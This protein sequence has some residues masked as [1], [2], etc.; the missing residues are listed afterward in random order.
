[1]FFACMLSYCSN[2]DRNIYTGFEPNTIII[3][4]RQP[5][6]CT[7][8]R[9]TTVHRMSE[10]QHDITFISL[11][12]DIG[13]PGLSLSKE[14]PI[15][16]EFHQNNKRKLNCKFVHSCLS[17]KTIILANMFSEYTNLT[18]IFFNNFY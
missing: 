1:M 13:F 4:M 9:R 14:R 15:S 16:N 11:V 6:E 3:T 18:K 7:V 17:C 8:E 10:V 12:P 5:S 2:S